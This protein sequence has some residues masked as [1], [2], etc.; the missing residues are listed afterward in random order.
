MNDMVRWKTDYRAAQMAYE[1][2][3]IGPEDVD[4]MECHD[5]FSI[6]EILHCEALGFCAPGEGGQLA[7]SGATGPGGHI[8]VNTSGGLLSRG[9]PVAATGVAQIA[10]LVVQLRREAGDRQVKNCSVGLAQCMGG[11]KDADTKS[12]TIAVLSR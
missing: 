12:C 1:A 8:P 6:S 2:A 11:D 9:H 7:E 10:E 5:A 3:G 4:L